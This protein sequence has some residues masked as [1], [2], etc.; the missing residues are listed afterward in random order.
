MCD[1]EKAI[2]IAGECETGELKA[3]KGI[4][5]FTSQSHD[6][7]REYEF[8]VLFW[9]SQSTHSFNSQSLSRL[10]LHTT[11]HRASAH[12]FIFKYA[13]EHKI[14]INL[15]CDVPGSCEKQTTTILSHQFHAP[16][17]RLVSA[18]K[19]R[20]SYEWRLVS[21]SRFFRIGKRRRQK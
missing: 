16:A 4:Q 8:Y 9:Y 7:R 14:K 17:T 2:F 12:L 10:I 3:S 1:D 13:N 19:S 6:S 21:F 18:G 11:A 5:L 20:I 15:S